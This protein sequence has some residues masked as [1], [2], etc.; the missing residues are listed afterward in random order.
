[1]NSITCSAPDIACKLEFINM[2]SVVVSFENLENI[3]ILYILIIFL[4]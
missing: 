4:A 2:F 3:Y 1:M